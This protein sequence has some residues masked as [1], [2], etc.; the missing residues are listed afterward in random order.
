MSIQALSEIEGS[1]E[2]KELRP[3][4]NLIPGV[5]QEYKKTYVK[6]PLELKD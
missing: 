6:V 4:N 5:F 2:K 3:R 1:L